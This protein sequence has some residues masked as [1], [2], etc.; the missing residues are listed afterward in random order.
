MKGG[1]ELFAGHFFV[2]FLIPKEPPTNLKWVIVEE[3]EETTGRAAAQTAFESGQ[4][5]SGLTI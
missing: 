2:W 5:D 3:E 4:P 1:F